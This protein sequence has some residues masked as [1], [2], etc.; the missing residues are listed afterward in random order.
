MSKIVLAAVCL[1]LTSVATCCGQS[2]EEKLK[3]IADSHK[4]V[5]AIAVKQLDT[6]ESCYLNADRV[7]PTA[8]LIKLPIMIEAYRQAAVEG[9]DLQKLISLRDEDK[10]PGS[11][12]L[13]DHFS[14]SIHDRCSPCINGC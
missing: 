2:L 10:V 4:G 13:T 9:L 14:D 1:L 3:T 12:V 8:S 5:V 7:M 11:G 6:N